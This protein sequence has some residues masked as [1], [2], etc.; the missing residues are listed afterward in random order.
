MPTGKDKVNSTIISLY[1]I[2]LRGGA[3]DGVRSN[4]IKQTR[5]LDPQYES[6]VADLVRNE[7][8][9]AVSSRCF[10]GFGLLPLYELLRAN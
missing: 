9:R 8:T 1:F 2:A 7:G 5:H 6:A 3:S 4:I 10:R